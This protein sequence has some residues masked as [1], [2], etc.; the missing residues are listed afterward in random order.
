[1]VNRS[2]E[3]GEYNKPRE[4]FVHSKEDLT[5]QRM[6]VKGELQLFRESCSISVGESKDQGKKIKGMRVPTK[7]AIHAMLWI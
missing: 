4:Q 6:I 1:M 5:E 2:L 7:K 3:R